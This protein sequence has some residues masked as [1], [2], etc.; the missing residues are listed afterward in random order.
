MKRA[1]VSI[2]LLP[3]LVACGA[4]LSNGA[5]ESADSSTPI[6]EAD[7]DTDADADSDADAD[8]D[9][10]SDAD[11]DADSDA[12]DT[13]D[14]VFEHDTGIALSD[15]ED[16]LILELDWFESSPEA[17]LAG[18][19]SFAQ[20]HVIDANEDRWAPPVIEERA[21]LALFE[22]DL[23]LE[24]DTDV[25]LM[26]Q[27]ETG[28]LGVLQLNPPSKLPTPLEQSLTSVPL[29]AWSETAWSVMLPWNWVKEGV[30][31]TIGAN[32]PDG[33]STFTHTLEGLAPPEQFTI[34]R[35]KM[36]LFGDSD[37]DTFTQPAERV[38]GDFFASWPSA[39]LRWVDS[40]PWILD[41]IVVRAE[42]G[43]VVVSSEGERTALTSDP[44]R[45]HILKHQF[46]I[47]MSLAN[48]GRGLVKT[49]GGDSSPYSFGTSVGSGWVM[50]DDGSY[51]DL[52]NAPYA[53]GWTGWT[54][55]WLG[56]CAN[57]FIHEVGHS[58]TLLHFTEGTASSWSIADEYPLDGVNLSTHPWGFDT[59]RE[60]FRTWYR[61]DSSGPVETSGGDWQGKRDPMNGGE[62]PNAASCFPQFTPYHAW[63]VN[64]WLT[65]TPA[66]REVDGVPGIYSWN[67]A[68]RA[69][70]P[71]E[72][73]EPGSMPVRDIDVPVAT[74]VGAFGH[75]PDVARIYPPIYW[76][77]GN[78]FDYPDATESGL[79]DVYS[80][81]Q[82]HLKV[83]YADSS[84]EY[85]AIAADAIEHTDTDLYLFSVNLPLDREPVRV[86]LQTTLS[87]YPDLDFSTANLLATID[88]DG[89][90]AQTPEPVISGRGFMA[91]G[92]VFLSK[93]CEPGLNCEARSAETLWRWNE[94]ELYFE[95]PEATGDSTVI[96]SELDEHSILRLP[97]IDTDGNEELLV[98]HA[99]RVVKADGLEIAVPIHD[100]TPWIDRPNRQQGLRLWLPFEDNAELAPGTWTL[101]EPYLITAKAD[102]EDQAQIPLNI[103]LQTY[104]AE[105]LNLAETTY[106]GPSYTAPVESSTYFVVEDGNVGPTSGAWWGDSEPTPLSVPVID[107][108]TGELNTLHVN[109]WKR[110]CALGWSTWWNL[111]SAQVADS[112][113]DQWVYM[114]LGDNSH[115][116]P[117]HHYRSPD[118][119]PIVMRAMQWHSGGGEL[120]RDAYLFE[121]TAG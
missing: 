71:A 50:N 48:T 66:I 76:S 89:S 15:C 105:R 39:E 21:A 121:H 100:V 80:G 34:S 42:G 13:S 43:P 56:E 1:S 55:M 111:N 103:Q 22:V 92:E 12:D 18:N 112:S 45:W 33:L 3:F 88:I 97:I 118:S 72:P 25:R 84:V 113:C 47:R 62:G 99:Q 10:D 20:T 74:I 16:D 86:S 36:V 9:A 52:D 93:L 54:A 114:E 115:L 57:V 8:A 58:G 67:A 83:E 117:G 27:N 46:A 38:A 11:A 78:V 101:Q 102:G 23:P 96:C 106:D 60:R 94:Q 2:G 61:V 95:D 6:E 82:Y 79:D 63:Q 4:K 40:A 91:N 30:E 5:L 28:P 87:A 90:T 75:N 119:V 32:G 31:L 77:S 65:T 85:M 116:T 26:A 53:A 64:D 81:S 59:I 108:T 41:E 68:T 107:D 35:S 29:A 51:S 69:Y 14:I 17:G 70:E 98:V 120:G 73:A 19:L 104:A 24:D 37:K 7:A 49:S 109:A 44:D 110:S